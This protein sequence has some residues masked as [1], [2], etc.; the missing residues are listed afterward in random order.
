MK[1]SEKIIVSFL[2]LFIFAILVYAANEQ[3]TEFG[4]DTII[5]CTIG[6]HTG[7]LNCSGPAYFAN[8]TVNISTQG[9]VNA[10]KFYGA[11]IGDGSGVTGLPLG[12]GAWK[13]ANFSLAFSDVYNLTKPIENDSDASLKSINAT[14]YYNGSGDLNWITCANVLDI[15]KSCV[16][17]DLNTWVDIAGDNM[18]GTLTVGNFKVNMSTT[19]DVNGTNAYFSSY[20]GDGSSLSGVAGSINGSAISVTSINSTKINISNGTDY[21]FHHNGSCWIIRAGSTEGRICE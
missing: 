3:P 7:I 5:T 16:E 18:T 13:L 20:F 4:D 10:T 12:A 14:N 17:S 2:V 6:G 15:D 11:F 8:G 1:I 19:G 21:S 9:D